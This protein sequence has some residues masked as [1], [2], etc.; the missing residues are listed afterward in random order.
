MPRSRSSTTKKGH[1]GRADVKL[2]NESFADL[3]RLFQAGEAHT[4]GLRQALAPATRKKSIENPDGTMARLPQLLEVARQHN[5]KIVSI[6]DLVAYRMRT[7]RLVRR[8]VSTP[9]KTIFGDFEA[10]AY[11]DVTSSTLVLRGKTDAK[12]K[13]GEVIVGGG[14]KGRLLIL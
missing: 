4:A 10:M 9:M 2:L 6:D 3:E 1:L 12:S 13:T 11:T 5:L 7:E 14:T 8:E